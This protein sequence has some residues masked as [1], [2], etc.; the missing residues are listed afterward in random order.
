MEILIRALVYFRFA[1]LG[2]VAYLLLRR[3]SDG[4][5]NAVFALGVCVQAIVI[6][7]DILS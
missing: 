2:G 7:F 4:L 6:L 3:F 5:A 1:L